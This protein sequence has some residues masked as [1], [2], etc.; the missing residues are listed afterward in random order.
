MSAWVLAT[1]FP[2]CWTSQQ[3]VSSGLHLSS[4]A[5]SI[6]GRSVAHQR[7]RGGDVLGGVRGAHGDAM[8]IA[9]TPILVPNLSRTAHHPP[10]T[11]AT[12]D[13]RGATQGH[14]N[15]AAPGCHP[16]EYSGHVCQARASPLRA[17]GQTTKNTG[18]PES[19]TCTCVRLWDHRCTAR[20]QSPR[21]VSGGPSTGSAGGAAGAGAVSAP[22]SPATVR[23]WWG[24]A[25]AAARGAARWRGAPRPRDARAM[26]PWTACPCHAPTSFRVARASSRLLAPASSIGTGRGPGS[27][28]L[29]TGSVLPWLLESS[30]PHTRQCVHRTIPRHHERSIPLAS[31]PVG[32]A[33][34]LGPFSAGGMLV[35]AARLL[36]LRW[37]AHGA[38]RRSR[39]AQS[40]GLEDCTGDCTGASADCPSSFPAA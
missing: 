23:S 28:R 39:S 16:T 18:T 20:G 11:P 5:G 7:T 6:C 25:H 12:Q 17:H 37:S 29:K 36:T 22:A 13:G 8:R 35:S 27:P 9:G 14:H 32:R 38:V 1:W 21:A 31:P 3:K 2:N 33:L 34:F 26:P 19:G 10:V 30:P 4:G 40:P 15:T 24:A